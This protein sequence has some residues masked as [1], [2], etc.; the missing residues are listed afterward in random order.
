[1]L[2]LP[3]VVPF[4]NQMLRL[5]HVK[6]VEIP[7]LN[8]WIGESGCE[9]RSVLHGPGAQHKPIIDSKDGLWAPT[10]RARRKHRGYQLCHSCIIV[11]R[12]RTARDEKPRAH[13]SARWQ[14]LMGLDKTTL[15]SDAVSEP[16][17]L[18]I[19]LGKPN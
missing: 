12:A 16:L 4:H 2:A 9:C 17:M 3:R 14:N 1:M 15:G 8:V 13:A 11:H 10:H 18:L 19:C 5:G 7:V 6:G